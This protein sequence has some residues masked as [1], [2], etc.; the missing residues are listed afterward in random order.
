MA[1]LSQR[2]YLRDS[3]GPRAVDSGYGSDRGY[4]GGRRRRN[5][6]DQS[7]Q[8]PRRNSSLKPAKPETGHRRRPSKT[9]PNRGFQERPTFELDVIGQPS[10]AVAL[11]MEV[12]LSVMV[13]LRLL[14]TDQIASTC[15]VDTGSLLAV[16][17]LVAD[18]RSGER[19]P[20]EAGAMTGQKMFDS[21][22]PIPEECVEDLARNQPCRL[23][24]GYFSF[25]GLL[26]RQA[27]TYRV[28]VTLLKMAA[29]MGEGGSSVLAIDSDPIKIERRVIAQSRR[30]R[31]L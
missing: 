23:A 5:S 11:G 16:T 15:S 1:D 19:F 24:L 2:S 14:P 21:V 7:Q 31:R 6:G 28:R 12:E 27:G 10:R 3:T 22:H 29:G 25:P 9:Q 30:H 8:R 4:N 17:S 26:I 13:S 20:V 18:T